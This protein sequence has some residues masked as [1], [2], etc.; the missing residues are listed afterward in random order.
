[1][2]GAVWSKQNIYVL[3]SLGLCE[4]YKEI[5]IIRMHFIDEDTE[6]MNGPDR[7]LVKESMFGS[8][9]KHA[10]LTSRPSYKDKWSDSLPSARTQYVFSRWE[11]FGK[12]LAWVGQQAEVTLQREVTLKQGS[13]R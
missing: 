13:W 4:K 1:M 10:F 2:L 6:A 12:G 8:W 3:F 7:L 5:A 9:P 11:R